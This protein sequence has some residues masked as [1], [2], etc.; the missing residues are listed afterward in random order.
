MMPG[1]EMG[2]DMAERCE[3][4]KRPELKMAQAHPTRHPDGIPALC[5]IECI[6]QKHQLY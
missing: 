5:Q 1:K 2:S 6:N 4:G 3:L